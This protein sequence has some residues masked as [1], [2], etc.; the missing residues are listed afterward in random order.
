MD[1][2][3]RLGGPREGKLAD[4]KRKQGKTHREKIRY[5]T[6]LLLNKQLLSCV[7]AKGGDVI[8]KSPG[9]APK[10]TRRRY[11]LRAQISRP[12]KLQRND[13]IAGLESK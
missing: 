1:S 13:K 9:G 5:S 10:E 12:Q 2:F 11:P 8:H 6:Q 3:L 7:A 4:Q